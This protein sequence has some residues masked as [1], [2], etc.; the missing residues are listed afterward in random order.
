MPKNRRYDDDA[1]DDRGPND[2]SRIDDLVPAP[3]ERTGVEK[4]D[5]GVSLDGFELE[6]AGSDTDIPSIKEAFRGI[7]DG[8]YPTPSRSGAGTGRTEPS[9]VGRHHTGRRR[10][11]GGDT[12]VSKDDD[13]DEI[14]LPEMDNVGGPGDDL[15]DDEVA[16]KL[17]EL[18]AAATDDGA[19]EA[20]ETIHAYVAE[21]GRPATMS[22]VVAWA[23]AESDDADAVV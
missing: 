17:D 15:S 13:G 2:N 1:D 9:T 3:G 20:L 8:I 7:T 4:S 18:A 23:V 11:G 10:D 12:R 22:E 16:D 19:R 5:D 14:D 21:H 6:K